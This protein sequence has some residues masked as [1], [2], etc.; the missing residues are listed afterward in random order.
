M[1]PSRS[2]LSTRDFSIE[3]FRSPTA[4]RSPAPTP[5]PMPDDVRYFMERGEL[6]FDYRDLTPEQVS[7]RVKYIKELKALD[8]FTELGL[9]NAQYKKGIEQAKVYADQ[10]HYHNRFMLKHIRLSPNGEVI[11]SAEELV[12][13]LEWAQTHFSSLMTLASTDEQ[14]RYFAD[15]LQTAL[16]GSS[17]IEQSGSHPSSPFWF[18]LSATENRAL[19]MFNAPARAEDFL[20]AT[21]AW[22]GNDTLANN[23]SNMRAQ[24]IR[25]FDD[26]KG[27][28]FHLGS[29]TVNSGKGS[30]HSNATAKE[31]LVSYFTYFRENPL[32]TSI[33]RLLEA[34]KTSIFH[35]V[36]GEYTFAE[37]TFLRELFTEKEIGEIAQEFNT[38]IGAIETILLAK[39]RESWLLL[40]QTTFAAPF[41][42]AEHTLQQNYPHEIHLHRHNEGRFYAGGD[43]CQQFV[44]SLSLSTCILEEQFSHLQ[45]T[46]YFED[47]VNF[48]LHDITFTTADLYQ[49]DTPVNFLLFANTRIHWKAPKEF[50]HWIAHT[51]NP[52]EAAPIESVHMLRV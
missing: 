1:E 34:I 10:Y 28:V 41:S 43:R 30:A 4:G 5:L 25:D 44:C 38:T 40:N 3:D 8:R 29:S 27:L 19:A 9:I 2:C 20:S 49:S 50:I 48:S 11:C 7:E 37:Q 24:Y 23:L 47:V 17:T 42:F 39:L 18:R 33:S 35:Q 51:L 52:Q 36:L 22:V 31:L 13:V 46:E 32:T 45:Y 15:L 14:Q 12:D 26:R 21:L 6:S 16:V